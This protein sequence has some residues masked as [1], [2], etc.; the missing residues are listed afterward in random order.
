MGTVLFD[1][2]KNDIIEVR[3]IIGNASG[4]NELIKAVGWG[5]VIKL[6]ITYN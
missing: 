4:M 1:C 3:W 6:R 5:N 2:R